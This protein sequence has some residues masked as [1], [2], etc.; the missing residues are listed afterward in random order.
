MLFLFLTP[1]PPPLAGTAWEVT[2]GQAY[3]RVTALASAGDVNGDGYD[4][5][6]VG[7]SGYDHPQNAEGGAALFLGGPAGLSATP[8]WAAEGNRASY[9]FGGSV[10]SAGDVNG[11]GYDDVIVGAEDYSGGFGNS[12]GA[13]FVYHGNAGGL[14]ANPAWTGGTGQRDTRFGQVVASA[15]DV[16]GDGY[17]DVIVG[18]PYQD[19]A[20]ADGGAVYVFHGGPAGLSAVASWFVEGTRAFSSWGQAVASAGDVNAD[21]FDDVVIETDDAVALFLGGPGGLA[22]A[23]AWTVV[24]PFLNISFGHALA[25]GDVNGDGFDDV[26]LGAAGDDAAAPNAGLVLVYLGGPGG[27]GPNPDWSVTGAAQ[28]DA[29]GLSVAS[30]GDVDAD[31]YDDLVVGCPSWNLVAPGSARLYRGGP[32]GLALAPGWSR[33]GDQPGAGFGES[34]A[35]GGDVDGDGRDDLLI[36]ADAADG[37]QVDEGA[38]YLFDDFGDSDGDG[39]LDG[40]DNCPAAA[41]PDQADADADGIGDACDAPSLVISGV[42]LPGRAL[43]LVAGGVVPGETVGFYGAVGTGGVGPCVPGLCLDLGANAVQLGSAVADATGVATLAAVVPGALP[44]VPTLAQAVVLRGTDSA[45]SPVVADTDGDGLLDPDELALGLDPLDP[46]VDGDGVLDGQDVCLFGDDRLDTDGDGVPDAC[47]TCPSDPNPSQADSDGD[48]VGNACEPWTLV[49]GVWVD[50]GGQVD[51]GFGSDVGSAGDVN[52]DGYDD[53]LVVAAGSGSASVYLGGPAGPAVIASWSSSAG[54][55]AAAA[56]DVNG[57][58]YDDLVMG[59]PD[60]SVTAFEGAAVVY[61]GSPAGLSINPAWAVAGQRSW[62]HLGTSVASAGDVDGDGYD[63]VVVGTDGQRGAEEGFLYLGGPTGLSA[64]PDWSVR[65]AAAYGDVVAVL[66]SAGDVNGDGYDDVVLLESDPS[67][68]AAGSAELFLGGPAGLAATGTAIGSSWPTPPTGGAAGDV[69]ADG[70]ADVVLSGEL[71]GVGSG[72]YVFAGGPSGPSSVATWS[73]AV[74]REVLVAA[75][76]IDGDGY[77]DLVGSGE[78]GRATV[79]LGGPDGPSPA[80]AWTRTMPVANVAGSAGDVNGD[81]YGDLV[82]GLPSYTFAFAGE[83]AAQVFF[84]AAP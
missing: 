15:G 68:Y 24:S 78:T 60:Y 29:C 54:P 53:L 2:T 84:G 73:W 18:A 69:D 62:I 72:W 79:F 20:N 56:G 19:G 37:T 31:G 41:N 25:S 67:G 1:P 38:A 11:D 10:A 64:A 23:P 48:G 26:V 61:L 43:E 32:T 33:L 63:D 57:D 75:G 36:A 82:F 76:D 3:A 7:S 55:T 49:A 16:N 42:V 81:G 47:D 14:S 70:Y 27:P 51:A 80:S 40:G 30:A 39:W 59:V 21:G 35:F 44:S 74:E 65:S 13:A 71:A 9:F 52:G 5:V 77:D 4:D 34:V 66:E 17:D 50:T 22:A 46:D 8:S 45:T 12:G 6:I 58:G 83:G 28:D